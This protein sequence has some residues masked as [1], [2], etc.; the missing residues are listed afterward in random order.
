MIVGVALRGENIIIMLPRP[1]RHCN[2]F[3]YAASIGIDCVKVKLGTKAVD[4]GF[5]T[6]TGKYLNR[7]QAAKYVKRIKQETV[8]P[9]GA[10]LFSETMW[11]DK[12]PPKPEGLE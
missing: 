8:E 7:E 9:V 12:T 11:D 2:C 6:H 3:W 4:Q 1:N 10:Y 5:Y